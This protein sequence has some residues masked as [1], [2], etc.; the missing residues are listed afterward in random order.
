[1][2]HRSVMTISQFRKI[3]SELGGKTLDEYQM[4]LSKD[5]EGNEFLPILNNIELSIGIDEDQKRII[6]FPSHFCGS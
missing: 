1:M 2:T 5:E 6:L 3:L 4:W